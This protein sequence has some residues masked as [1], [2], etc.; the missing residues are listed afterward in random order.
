ME[1]RYREPWYRS[2]RAQLVNYNQYVG[3]QDVNSR[4]FISSVELMMKELEKDPNTAYIA[5]A[6]KM[7]FID[8][9][10]T[11]AGAAIKLGYSERQ[12][13]R[14]LNIFVYSIGEMIGW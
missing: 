8:H 13:R 2:V 11:M 14:V 7:V 6:V 9:T 5:K 3:R 1:R 4:V 10:H 12:I